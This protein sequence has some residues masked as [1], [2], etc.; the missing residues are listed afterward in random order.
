M[1]AELIYKARQS[2]GDD[3]FYEVVI[4]RLPAPVPGSAHPFKYRMAL[5]RRG[6]CVMRYD[7]ERGKG[8]HRH[9]HGREEPVRFT[10][11]KALFEAFLADAERVLE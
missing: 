6:E 9:I 7:N 1:K 3:T 4:W 8:D 11:M 2:L 10:T 5:V